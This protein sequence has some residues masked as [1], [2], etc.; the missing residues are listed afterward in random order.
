MPAPPKKTL[1]TYMSLIPHVIVSK[2]V[3]FD[4]RFELHSNFI[5]NAFFLLGGGG[6]LCQ[7]QC[8]R[9]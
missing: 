5:C 4:K 2:K 6:A 8:L 1:G 3:F 9:S 7:L